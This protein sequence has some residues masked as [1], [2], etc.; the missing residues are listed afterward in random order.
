MIA[1]LRQ[2]ILL[3]KKKIQG[4]MQGAAEKLLV[5]KTQTRVLKHNTTE[6][7]IQEF[8]Q[9]AV[10]KLFVCKNTNIHMY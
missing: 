1:W 9:D 6:N 5:C 8:M 4:F 3:Q 10:E 2:A 7:N